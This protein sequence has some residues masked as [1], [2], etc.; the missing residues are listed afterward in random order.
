MPKLLTTPFA[1]ES[2]LRTNIQESQGAESNS[3][4][5]R[6][7]FPEETMKKIALGG[8]PPK[9]EDMN[10]I[11]YDLSEN[12]VFQTQGG[13]YKFD[14][15][16]ANKIGG[17]PVKAVLQL[18]NGAEVIN[19][20]PNNTTNPNV[21]MTGWGFASATKDSELMTWSGRTQESVNKD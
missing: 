10:G 17:Y 21:D 4:T 19:K 11:L 8:K 13:R 1:A 7:G 9:G 5:Y 6:F 20:T 14:P 12:I 18:E 2:Q 15:T 3:A 16:Y